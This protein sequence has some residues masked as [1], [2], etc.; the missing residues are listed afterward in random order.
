MVTALTLGCA[1]V[2]ALAALLVVFSTDVMH[3][4]LA[5]IVVLVALA[6]VY[7][8]L[9]AHFIAAIQIAVY[10]G[11]IMILFL[12]AIMVLEGR[13]EHAPR[14]ASNRLHRL[15]AVLAG[16]AMLLGLVA[17]LKTL[18]ADPGALQA[19]A[20]S[21]RDLSHLLF[22]EW[23]LP[24]ELVGLLLFVA[25]VAVMVLTRPYLAARAKAADR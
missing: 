7:A 18:G 22:G 16:G 2:A 8:G 6:G 4:A 23:L 15:A 20:P 19:T 21:I 13:R 9:G 1:L 11:A 5:L 17:G 12:F 14:L 24:F 3:G 10:A 25:L